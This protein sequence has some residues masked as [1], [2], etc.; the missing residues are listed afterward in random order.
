MIFPISKII[1]RPSVYFEAL[2]RIDW[3]SS[4][5]EGIFHAFSLP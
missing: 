1:P 3:L 4:E 2:F 5:K